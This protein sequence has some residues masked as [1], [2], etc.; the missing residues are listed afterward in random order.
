MS[1]K[2]LLQIILFLLIII[3]VG[4][5]YVIYFYAGPIKNNEIIGDIIVKSGKL[6]FSTGRMFLIVV[7]KNGE[8]Y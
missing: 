1:V 5:I 3:I 8:R 7:V 2:S 4:G 6:Q